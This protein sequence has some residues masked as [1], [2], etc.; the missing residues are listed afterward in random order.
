MKL[1][2]QELCK[3]HVDLHGDGW[4]R[5][6]DDINTH[7]PGSAHHLLHYSLHV[8]SS[9]VGVYQVLDFCDFIQVLNTD[10]RYIF[11][12]R[13]LTSF[14]RWCGFLNE[15]GGGWWLYHKCEASVDVCCELNTHRR[16]FLELTSSFIELLTELHH[17]HTQR[18]K[19]LTNFGRRLGYTG[20]TIHSNTCLHRRSR[21]HF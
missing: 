18:T 10:F 4:E 19:R 8:M 2:H 12:A 6:L 1:S 16:V 15:P 17:I 20:K 13:F 11:M 21:I 14:E 3:S 5:V 9:E 7:A